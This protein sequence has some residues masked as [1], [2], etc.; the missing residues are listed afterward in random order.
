[1][2]N[3][4]ENSC[5]NFDFFWLDGGLDRVK[6]LLGFFLRH[7]MLFDKQMVGQGIDGKTF[8]VKFERK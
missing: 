8:L 4:I 3:N 7:E 6:Y 2:V 5:L 1:M